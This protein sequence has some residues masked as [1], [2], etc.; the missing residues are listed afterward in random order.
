MTRLRISLRN[1]IKRWCRN[2]VIWN[3]TITRPRSEVAFHMVTL[4][5][6]VPILDRTIT[7]V[8]CIFDKLHYASFSRFSFNIVEIHL[9]NDKGKRVPFTTGT[10]VVTLYFWLCNA[11][12]FNKW[13]WWDTR[14]FDAIPNFM[15]NFSVSKQV[16]KCPCLLVVVVKEV[17]G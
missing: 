9:T 13:K 8:F 1:W 4:L 6:S 16:I 14:L 3:S 17:I 11:F 10:S 2:M 12:N 15:K 5:R 7:S